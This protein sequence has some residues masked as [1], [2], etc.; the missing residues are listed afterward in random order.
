MKVVGELDA[1]AASEP[2]AAIAPDADLTILDRSGLKAARAQELER[3]ETARGPERQKFV[4]DLGAFYN[5]MADAKLS[6]V[7]TGTADAEARR[8][9]AALR[10][11]DTGLRRLTDNEIGLA[12]RPE[13]A[14]S[15]LQTQRQALGDIR[16]WMD[17]E[18]GR[19]QHNV[20]ENRPVIHSELMANKIEGYVGSALTAE[21]RQRAVDRELVR[22]F[23]G[24]IIEED[25]MRHIE[26]PANIS[27]QRFEQVEQA[28]ERNK[29]LQEQLARVT[30]DPV[31]ARLQQ[32]DEA[33]HALGG[34][35][36]A[37][38]PVPSSSPIGHA[39][40]LAAHAAGPLG[41]VAS[42]AMGA[43]GGLRK[44]AG[45]GIERAGRAASNFLA[46]AGPIAGKAAPHA[47]VLATKALAAL[48]YGDR[49]DDESAGD[50]KEP[51]T[52]P[53]LY[54][55][56]TDEVKRQVHI[57]ADGTF[58]M[59]PEARQKMAAK[60]SGIGAVDPV[61]ADRL[62]SAGAKRIAWLASQIPR[63]P[64]M[65]GMQVG[66]DTWHPSDMEMRAWAR[67]AAA[68]ED[69]HGVLERVV[70]GTVTPEDVMA[71]KALAPEMRADFVNAVSA[72][73]PA[74]HKS[75]SFE[76]QLALS[77]FSGV[78]VTPA[79]D[80]RVLVFLQSQFATEPG[81]EGGT[82]APKPQPQFG[83]LKKATPTPA[84][85]RAQ[86]AHV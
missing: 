28:I 23:G 1:A 12:E 62:E 34:R 7:V 45:A 60:L 84:Q 5:D 55:A 42:T 18:M 53:E 66:P 51:R 80:P 74:L 16:D 81:S 26:Y 63:R 24:S 13:K 31:S 22:R 17:E 86:G 33:E 57:A 43:I 82:Q 10:N 21:G 48:R 9:G 65:A 29:V 6:K 27:I 68:A 39:L 8:A 20:R 58:Q 32:I 30:A 54:K 3:I 73:L 79:L 70:H 47:P 38:A 14:L 19:W 67:K 2:A 83:S 78:P 4:S 59:R 46:V 69:L 56:R 64:D 15:A 72:H 11:A 77:L 44:A 75:L 61:A 37:P 25:G 71:M 41:T 52:L 49:E 85:V 35:T 36:S 50:H 76:R 40:K